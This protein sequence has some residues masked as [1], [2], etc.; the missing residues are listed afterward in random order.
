M[1]TEEKGSMKEKVD[2]MQ[3][4]YDVSLPA[5]IQTHSVVSRFKDRPWLLN[6]YSEACGGVI[7]IS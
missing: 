1:K 2:S 4:K 3:K 7:I 6:S 5:C